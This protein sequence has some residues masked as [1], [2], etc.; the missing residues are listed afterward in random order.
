MP[1][2]GM[3]SLLPSLALV[4]DTLAMY[5]FGAVGSAGGLKVTV[6]SQRWPDTITFG[7]EVRFKW[8][9]AAPSPSIVMSLV[10][11]PQSGPART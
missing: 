2:S 3:Y 11:R 9:A 4:M 6:N 1:V 5:G 8:N 10:F 7:H